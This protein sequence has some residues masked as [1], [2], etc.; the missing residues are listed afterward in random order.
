MNAWEIALGVIPGDNVV[1]TREVTSVV[2]ASDRTR[3]I[4]ASARNIG[5][6]ILHQTYPASTKKE[7]RIRERSIW[8]PGEYISVSQVTHVRKAA[9]S[10]KSK[11]VVWMVWSVVP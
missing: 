6:S 8:Y 7:I 3:G 11:A 2:D 5:A 4:Q 10:D 1:V 9:V